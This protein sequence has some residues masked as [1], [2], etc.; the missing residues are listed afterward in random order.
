MLTFED[1]VK[2]GLYGLLVGDACGVP[3]EFTHP[4]CLPAFDDLEMEPPKGFMRSY[5]HVPLGTWSDDGAQ[6]LCLLDTLMACEGYHAHHFSRRLLR[7]HEDGYL[8]VDNYVFDVGNQTSVSIARLK[9]GMTVDYSGM[10]GVRNNGNGSLMRSL[11]LALLHSGND[12]SLLMDAHRQSRLTHAHLRSQICCGLYCLWA[13]RELQGHSRAWE[14]A[15]ESAHKLYMDS[16]E[17]LRELEEHILVHDKPTGSGYVVDALH[18]AL[19]A[20]EGEDYPTIIKRA[21][22]LGNDTDTTACIAGGIAG[23]RHGLEGI[24]L[25]WLGKLRGREILGPILLRL[26]E[27]I[28]ESAK[29]HC[30]RAVLQ[31]Q[32]DILGRS[33]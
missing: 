21:I 32:E 6:A 18:S 31:A 13:R 3:Y 33:D 11:P 25:R 27:A 1:R 8:A 4:A 19:H 9:Q 26:E 17:H 22:A 29:L 28:A 7:W 14:G 23:I 24:P 20:C 15:L 12:R 16:P 10:R 5:A 2:G 30:L